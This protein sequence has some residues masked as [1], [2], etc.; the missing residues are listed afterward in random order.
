MN[1]IKIQYIGKNLVD[2]LADCHGNELAKA[3]LTAALK[4]A[5]KI[6]TSLDVLMGKTKKCNR[7]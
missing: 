2:E 3:I 5:K 7:Y 4:R 1:A 6:Q